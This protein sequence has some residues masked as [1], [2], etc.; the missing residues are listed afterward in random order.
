MT[1]KSHKEWFAAAV[2]EL[3]QREEE[4]ARREQ[5]LVEREA[6]LAEREARIKAAIAEARF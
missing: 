2:A 4:L 5:R 3:E 1:T 6:V